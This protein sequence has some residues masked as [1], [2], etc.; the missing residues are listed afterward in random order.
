MDALG[1]LS[2]LNPSNAARCGQLKPFV[3]D[4]P[5]RE[6]AYARGTLTLFPEDHWFFQLCF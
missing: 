2:D 1:G 5:E 6:E 4:T 3:A